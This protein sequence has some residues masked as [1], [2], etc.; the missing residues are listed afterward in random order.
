[1]RRDQEAEK[2]NTDGRVGPLAGLNVIEFGWYYAGPMTGMLLGDQGA[3]VIRIVK[4]GVRELPEQQYR[5]LNRNKKLVELDLKTG[6]GLKAARALIAKADVL[7]ENF[8]PGVMNRLGIGAD[9]AAALNRRLIYLSLPGFASTDDQRCNIQAWEGVIAAATGVFT[10]TSICRQTL[11]YPPL[12]TSIPQNS[13]YGAMIGA[14]AVM[15]ALIGRGKTGLGGAIETPLADAAISGYLVNVALPGG[16]FRSQFQEPSEPPDAARDFVFAPGDD[17]AQAQKKIA[18]WTR[19]V[20]LGDP[21]ARLYKCS[22]DRDLLVWMP[23]QP[24]LIERFLKTLGLYTEFAEEGVVNKGPLDLLGLTN[25]LSSS[26]VRSPEL[27]AKIRDRVASCFKSD[28]ARV[29][30]ERM[31]RARLPVIMVRTRAEWMSEGEL[32]DAGVF[33]LMNNGASALTSPD[34][35]VDVH[36]LGG[37]NSRFVH[38]EYEQVTPGEAE[39]FFEPLAVLNHVHCDDET[40]KGDLLKDFKVLDLTNV[41][42]GPTSTYALAQYGADV[43]RLESPTSLHHP[44]LQK[45]LMEVMQQKRSV[46]ADLTTAPGREIFR[47]LVQWADIVVHNSVGETASRLGVTLRQLQEI[48]PDVL[49]CQLCAFGGA[50][51]GGWEGRPG[52][53]WSAQ[54]VTGLMARYGSVEEPHM[55]GGTSTGD[56]IG[57]LA[58][59]LA[60]M[61][62]YFQKLRT[63]VS[64]EGRTSLARVNNFMQLPFMISEG[65]RTDWGEPHGYFAKGPHWSQRLYRCS[66]GW[67]FAGASKDAA[68]AFFARIT[69]G[70]PTGA[71]GDETVL[72]RAFEEQ[73]CSYWEERLNEA[74]FGCHRVRSINDIC[75]PEFVRRVNASAQTEKAAG[76]I[77]ILSVDDHPCGVPIT[78]MAPTWARFG[79]DQHYFRLGPCARPGEHTRSVLSDL[80]YSEEEINALFEQRVAFD[81]LPEL[82]P[83]KYYFEPE[84]GKTS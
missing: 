62:A 21:F 36:M 46:L 8:R 67:V 4:P 42:A 28:P 52:F 65:G 16:V 82:G 22:D 30:E 11:N 61:L 35:T 51:R 27:S 12:Y 79:A 84:I 56:T 60:S 81:C 73:T 55:H 14:G 29:W 75:A 43:I 59:A 13:A 49:S 68:G 76:G 20:V 24:S 83:E 33:A 5:V 57:G 17:E 80:D 23:D 7:I 32:I 34:K 37:G 63:G 10:D 15:A 78:I 41:I 25:N 39:A 48:N 69:G 31:A 9:V 38:S 1:M 71:A 44:Y 2:S 50:G 53:D 18:G 74:D 54:S 19:E 64:G 40:R 47:R 26:Y 6:Q 70:Q 72:E 77:E 3:N 45:V 66:D 58:A